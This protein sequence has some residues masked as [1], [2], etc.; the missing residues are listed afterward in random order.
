[1]LD[2]TI[3]SPEYVTQEF[4]IVHLFSDSCFSRLE[5]RVLIFT[6]HWQVYGHS[7]QRYRAN[8]KIW[9]VNYKYIGER[10]LAPSEAG[11]EKM[12]VKKL[13]EKLINGLSVAYQLVSAIC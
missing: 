9:N 12:R 3:N 11:S 7:M 8:T 1:M 13:I 10:K 4:F 5:R 2:S 6:E